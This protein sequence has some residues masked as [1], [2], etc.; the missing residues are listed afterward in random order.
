MEGLR[1]IID[2]LRLRLAGDARHDLEALAHRSCRWFRFGTHRRRRPISSS[3]NHCTRLQISCRGRTSFRARRVSARI[4]VPRSTGIWL[5][6]VRLRRASSLAQVARLR[7]SQRV[8]DGLAGV[9]GCHE[10]PGS[11]RATRLGPWRSS[12]SRN[13]SCGARVM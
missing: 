7:Q 13:R 1:S 9:V 2:H 8:P 12:H 6:G 5:P 11:W 3:R 4:P 10:P